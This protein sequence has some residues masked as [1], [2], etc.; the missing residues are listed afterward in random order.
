MTLALFYADPKEQLGP[1]EEE[2]NKGIKEL[3]AEVLLVRPRVILALGGLALETL[4]GLTKPLKWRGSYLYSKP[5]FGSVLVIPCLHPAAI[6]RMYPWRWFWCATLNKAA[7]RTH[8]IRQYALNGIFTSGQTFPSLWRYYDGSLETLTRDGN[9]LYQQTL[10][11][12][13]G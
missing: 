7:V 10:K 5:E 8:L 13:R 11:Q 3:Q 9:K 12:R 4:T 2:C 1:N 6:L